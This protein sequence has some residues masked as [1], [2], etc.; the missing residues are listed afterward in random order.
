MAGGQAV[1][2]LGE[3]CVDPVGAILGTGYL[4]FESPTGLEGLAKPNGSR[5]DVLAVIN[6][7]GKAGIF[8]KFIAQAKTEYHTICVWHI[9]NSIVR[10]ALKRY[11]FETELEIDATGEVLKGMR[12]DD[13][14]RVAKNAI[15]AEGKP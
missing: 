15:E 5:L 4:R 3:T 8:R 10:E 13:W 12:W 2:V 6:P 9:E 14:A 7:T 1:S 11:G